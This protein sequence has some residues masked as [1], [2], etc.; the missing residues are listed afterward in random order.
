MIIK[1]N[2]GDVRQASKELGV[3]SASISLAPERFAQ[4]LH[5]YAKEKLEEMESG[6]L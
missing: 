6:R 5:T 2:D 3:L 4:E 1:Q